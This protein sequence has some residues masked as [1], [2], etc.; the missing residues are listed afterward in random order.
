MIIAINILTLVHSGDK[1]RNVCIVLKN[2]FIVRAKDVQNHPF[3]IDFSKYR[4]I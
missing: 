1:L 2:Y 4:K 3:L